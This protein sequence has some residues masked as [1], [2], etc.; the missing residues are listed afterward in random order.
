MSSEISL[1]YLTPSLDVAKIENTGIKIGKMDLDLNSTEQ[2]TWDYESPVHVSMI[3]DINREQLFSE[4]GFGPS[5]NTE[6]VVHLVWF[7]TKTKQRGS[8]PR[9]VVQDRKN[10]LQV[11][12]EGPML[13]GELK[14]W[15]AI[16]LRRISNSGSHPLAAKTPGTRLWSSDPLRIQ[17]EGSGSRFT[18]VPVDFKQ[19]GRKPEGAM[20]KVEVGN[21]LHIPVEA[22]LRVYINISNRVSKRVLNSPASEEAKYWKL[23]LQTDVLTQ[24]VLHACTSVDESED[25]E[26]D[27]GTLGESLTNVV[28]QLFPKESLLDIATDTARISAVSHTYALKGIDL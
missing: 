23:L 28:E 27:P 20:W 11:M 6:I 19:S 25:T 16:T 3:V 8:G 9:Q 26:F 5:S 1:G 24:M 21:D 15:A 14:V 2:P 22:G 7:S 13:G 18:T 17:L 4:C 12:I 10:E